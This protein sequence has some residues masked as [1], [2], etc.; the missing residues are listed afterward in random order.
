MVTWT[1]FAILA[2]FLLQESTWEPVE[3]LDC[4]DLIETFEANYANKRSRRNFTPLTNFCKKK[5]YGHFI[6]LIKTRSGRGD[7]KKDKK[8]ERK[9]KG[10]AR[11]FD[12]V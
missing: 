12:K 4:P 9:Y 2:M 10:K 1:A 3:N 11:G 5:N 8:A 7:K 6:V